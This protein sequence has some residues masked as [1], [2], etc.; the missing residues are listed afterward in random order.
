MNVKNKKIYV[1]IKN[2]E[3][4]YLNK[5]KEC[6]EDKNKYLE[7]N[8]NM[9]IGN[10]IHKKIK[11][12]SLDGNKSMSNFNE[13]SY[14]IKKKFNAIETNIKPKRYSMKSFTKSMSANI[15][16]IKFKNTNMNTKTNKPILKNLN[17][18]YIIKSSSEIIDLFNKYRNLSKNNK[19]TDFISKKADDYSK[20]KYSMQEK[21]LINNQKN[22]LKNKKISHFLSIKSGKKENSL[23][24]N[25]ND[26]YLMKRQLLNYLNSKKIL[27]EKFG[28]YYWLLNLRRSDKG[29]KEFKA[30]YINIGNDKHEIWERFYDTG[31]DDLELI[32]KNNSYENEIN[33]E[34]KKF[35]FLKT[36][37]GLKIEGK[38]LLEKEFSN[39]MEEIKTIEHNKS[40]CKI[41]L[42]K[43]PNEEK[44]KNIRNFIFK[45]NYLN[46]HS[47]SNDSKPLK[48]S[49]S[50]PYKNY[51][52]N[53]NQNFKKR[54]LKY[55]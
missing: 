29:Q 2:N 47:L 39:F 22:K 15:S 48:K 55:I 46:K 51:L 23:M 19:N 36:F 31:N 42:Y 45:E 28:N 53:I 26:K 44:S 27:S 17:K 6:F 4:Y 16:N 18:Y 3:E 13:N 40:D 10:L 21:F 25:G 14:N 5:M 32:V 35:E 38:N 33:D 49:V 52:T 7:L 34:N 24:I 43:D 41:K 11:L 8:K 12:L 9:T 20:N 37:Y 30:N 54:E 1:A 50:S